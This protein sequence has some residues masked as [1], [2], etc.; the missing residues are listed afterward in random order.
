MP[1]YPGLMGLG[2]QLDQWNPSNRGPNQRNINIM[3][4]TNHLTSV[5]LDFK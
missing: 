1:F 2:S 5:T 4:F 3:P